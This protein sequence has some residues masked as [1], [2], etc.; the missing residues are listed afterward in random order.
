ML[1]ALLPVAA[2]AVAT[3]EVLSK[4]YRNDFQESAEQARARAE[5]TLERLGKEVEAKVA[6]L[7][8]P[9]DPF[10]G[11]LLQEFQ[12]S[13]QLSRE[14]LQQARS[15]GAPAAQ[16]LSRLDVFFVLDD[17][18]TVLVAPHYRP[19]V[20]EVDRTR[21][22]LARQRNGKPFVS[23]EPILERDAIHPK[24]V[25]LS[26]RV[27]RFGG[28]ELIV[29]GGS[30]VGADTL[31][32]I[33][34]P[35]AA[36]AR[37]VDANRAVLTPPVG[38]WSQVA[39]HTFR[40]PLVGSSDR[41]VAFV[42]VGVSSRSLEQVLS[43]ITVLSLGLGVLALVFTIVLGY[44]VS[45]RIT[46]ALD[47][48]VDGAHAAARGDLHHKVPIRTRDEIGEVAQA[49][50]TMMT[51]LDESKSRLVMAE[52]VAAWQEIARR[53]AHEIKNPLTPIQMAMETLRRTH[54]KRHP[55]F[56][57]VL[58]ESTR[59]VLE[60]STRLKRIVQEFSEFARMPPPQK[61]LCDLNEL[62]SAQLALYTGVVPV[63]KDLADIPN[64]E[65]DRDSVSQV[66]LNLVENARDALA[67]L[68][69]PS[70]GQ[71]RV[72]TRLVRDGRAVAL[73]VE[74]NGPG[75]PADTRDKVFTPYFTTKQKTGGS[76]LGLAIVHRIVSDH[77]GRI[78][79]VDS[80]LGG[81]RVV[82]ELPVPGASADEA[83]T[84]GRWLR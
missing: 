83:G 73:A 40:V 50:N 48:L 59:T 79:A 15:R 69:D 27:A 70:S 8:D 20:D 47:D 77:G 5:T 22:P 43:T 65:V 52:R 31:D 82:I 29:V 45:R 7:S 33:R 72:Q 75:I 3:R 17:S 41:P 36:D 34:R 39:S 68:P 32:A 62:V 80:E 35:P 49:L 67:G 53:I 66:I 30:A 46:G 55:S 63:E 56:D 21:A 23:L 71:I 60:E 14:V 26:A 57:E 13:G 84:S 44:L 1:A 64:V 78:M 28:R 11:G 2:A 4:N 19:A 61:R 58:D 38:D 16:K 54:E 81:A 51:E 6:A 18:D 74:D 10:V 12:K 25:M 24:L 9:D 42:E 37:I 76:G